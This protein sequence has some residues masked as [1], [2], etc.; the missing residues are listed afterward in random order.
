[1]HET[2]LIDLS[3]II[4]LGI[5]A[6]WISWRLHVPSIIFLLLIGFLAGPVTGILH[7]DA[8]FGPSLFPL[9]SLSVAI[10]LFEGGLSLSFR[11]LRGGENVLIRLISVGV[12]ITFILV[13]WLGTHLLQLPSSIAFL[14]GAILVV[15]GP[16][17]VVPLLLS[18]RIRGKIGSL[19]YW[20]GIVNDPIGA[21]LAVIVFEIVANAGNAAVAIAATAIIKTVLVAGITG[22][23]GAYI[24]IYLLKRYW[25]P[26][27]L[28]NPFALMLLTIV[29]AV[30]NTIQ[31]EAG[32]LAVTIMGIILANQR[33][34][35]V[36]HILEFKENLRVI[37]ISALFIILAS[38]LSIQ[39]IPWNDPKAYL[40]IGALILIVRPLAVLA[41]TVGSR[42]KWQERVLLF[43]MAPRGIVAA[44]VSSIFGLELVKQ[45]VA[46]G[47]LLMSYTFMAIIGTVLFYGITAR[48]VARALKLAHPN[49]QGVVFIGAHRWAR[50]LA[51]YLKRHHFD[52]LFI[53]TNKRNITY[54]ERDH[55]KAIRGNALDESL[56]E[57]LDFTPYGH[58]MAVTSNDEVNSLACMHYSELLGKSRV[59]QLA[60]EEM[61]TEAVISPWRGRTLFCS[62]CTFE[63]LEDAIHSEKSL[64][65]FSVQNN[66]EWETF[67]QNKQHQIIPLFLINEA[68]ELMLWAIDN[69]PQPESGDTVVYVHKPTSA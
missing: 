6:Q 38:R 26:D 51:R 44:A 68:Q 12:I 11:E 66:S 10:I 54:C 48:P 52:V 31:A 61:D 45:G 41:S 3:L 20:E 63:I 9:V 27:Y 53:D 4:I 42:L 7:P 37:L 60:A 46:Q 35:P 50:I 34:I 58:L 36:Q 28:H 64:H 15:T 56:I 30:S 57:K 8:L 29:F 17:V 16:T 67:W 19:I 62:Q 59:Y 47:N 25:V 24:L 5:L 22:G 65:A 21:T 2:V 13:A 14:L 55:L 33:K 39:D 40:F 23:L 69:P 18:L 49:P 43:W 1:M 32:L